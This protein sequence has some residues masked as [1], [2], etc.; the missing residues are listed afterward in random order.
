MIKIG[1]FITF[2]FS[3]GLIQYDWI[4]EQTLGIFLNATTNISSKHVDYI[5]FIERIIYLN[6]I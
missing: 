4:Y 5:N 6:T 1:L 3:E 2:I